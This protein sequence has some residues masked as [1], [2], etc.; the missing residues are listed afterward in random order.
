VV[1][2]SLSTAVAFGRVFVGHGPTWKLLAV[3]LASAVLAVAFERRSLLLATAVSAAACAVAVAIVV[4]P[5]SAWFGLPT[6]HTFHLAVAAAGQIGQEAKIQIAPT[7]PLAPLMLAG[8]VAV[9]AAVFSM[10]ALAVRTGSPLLGL[11][12]PISLLAFADTVLEETVKPQYGV[13]FL[14]AGLCLVFSD[15]LRRVQGWG[16]L[17]GLPASA[18]RARRWSMGSGARRMGLACIAA[19]LLAPI[20]LPGFGSKAVIDLSS[21]TGA[22]LNPLVSIRAQLDRT[23][24]L[25]LFRVQSPIAAYWRTVALDSFDGTTWRPE[26]SQDPVQIQP[27]TT[28]NAPGLSASVAIGGRFAQRFTITSDLGSEWLPAAYPASTVSSDVSLRYDLSSV[29]LS[30]D[31]PVRIGTLYTVTSPVIEPTPEQLDLSVFPHPAQDIRYTALPKDLPPEIGGLARDWTQGEPNDYRKILAIQDRLQSFTYDTT[32]APRD[33]ALSMIDFLT[34]TKRGF[35]QQFASSMAVMLRTL[36]I[37]ARVAVGFTP[38][39]FAPGTGTR[40]VT[41]SDYHAWV[42]VLFP[43]YGWLAFEPTPGRSNPLAAV[44]AQPAPTCTK[45]CGPGHGPGNGGGKP[46]P[47]DPPGVPKGS[48]GG[49]FTGTGQGP[50]SSGSGPWAP[51]ASAGVV[52]LLAALLGSPLWRGAARRARRRRAGHGVRGQILAT[53]RGFTDQASALGYPRAPGETIQEYR[54]RVVAQL[55]TVATPLERLSGLASEAAYGAVDPPTEMGRA[56]DEAA[57]AALDALRKTRTLQ[58]RLFGAYRPAKA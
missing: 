3:G 9:W 28:I 50:S 2:V 51:F 16:P 41:T 14:I 56:A 13:L 23:T 12:P 36:G 20:V 19:A 6:A 10:H 18:P 42:E 22:G 55:A 58:Q 33:D 4:F 39:N 7:Q 26:P 1:A 46:G 52:L 49:A 43:D 32:V 27:T 38:G 15:G 30:A 37:P 53:Y 11:L 31:G 35:C 5:D 45:G 17:W 48:R 29:S 24:P 8:V 21:S 40:V 57:R 47:V 34:V 44:Y 54:A 25:E